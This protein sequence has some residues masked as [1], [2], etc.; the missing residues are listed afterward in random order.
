MQMSDLEIEARIRELVK[1]ICGRK[2][3]EC[4][5]LSDDARLDESGWGLDS[6]DLGELSAAL[7]QEFSHD[8]YSRRIFP[9][10][11]R[12]IFDYYRHHRTPSS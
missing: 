5:G 12:E 1:R 11:L 7:E 4:D 2:G 9:L 3:L 10:T 8:P 6:L